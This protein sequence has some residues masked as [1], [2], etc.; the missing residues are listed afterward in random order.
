MLSRENTAAALS[1]GV[2]RS[3]KV[4][5]LGSHTRHVEHRATCSTDPRSSACKLVLASRFKMEENPPS[6]LQKGLL[7]VTVSGGM[8]LNG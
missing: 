4:Q 3:R 2:G 1:T 8:S 7:V 6:K 5:L